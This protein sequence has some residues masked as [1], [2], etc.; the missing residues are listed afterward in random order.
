[1]VHVSIITP[2]EE[3]TVAERG[4]VDYDITGATVKTALNE[5]SSAKL[6]IPF[7]NRRALALVNGILPTVAIYDGEK[8]AFIGSV[9]SCKRD[10]YGNM[11][12]DLDGPMSWLANIV[13]P[14]FTVPASAEMT[15]ATYLNRIINMQYNM[16]AE[17]IRA[18]FVGACTVDRTIA[19]SHS[20]EYTT[21]LDLLRELVSLY[22]GYIFENM[23]ANI[24]V[25]GD[26][27]TISYVPGAVGDSGQ[28][29]EFGV[30]EISLED[31]LDFSNYASRVYGVG[32]NG[33][34]VT[35]GYKINSTSEEKYGRKD[36]A[37]KS[38]AETQGE[39]DNE[40]KRTLDERSTPFRSIEMTAQEISR[41]NPN[42]NRFVI[43]TTARAL[44]RNLGEDINLIVNSV[45]RD[46][47]SHNNTKVVFGKAPLTMTDIVKSAS[48][49]V[50]SVAR[51]IFSNLGG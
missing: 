34:T 10:I 13:K 15:A 38:N 32:Q 43:G 49:K 7:T 31:Y 21:T 35:G 25:S 37:I 50:A 28:V 48:S 20:D 5:V 24:G 51:D 12:V 1:M 44:D 16:G 36:Y 11:E 23:G 33:L 45:E 8:R 18:V 19:V 9:A 2:Y 27:P 41:L 14:P 39:L 42:Y 22:G 46:L 3:T 30:N 4:N 6:K 29:L 17:A 47:V 26:T 40:A